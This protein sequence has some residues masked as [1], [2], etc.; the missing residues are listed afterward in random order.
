VSLAALG[1]VV[2]E[3]KDWTAYS[4][5]G[6][7]N[8]LFLESETEIGWTGDDGRPSVLVQV[9]RDFA[10]VTS[11]ARKQVNNPKVAKAVA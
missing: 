1:A 6:Y 7:S 10:L 11:P 9:C 4:S 3:W 5:E 2:Y 8:G